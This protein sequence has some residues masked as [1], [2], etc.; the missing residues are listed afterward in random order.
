M[1]TYANWK[2][3]LNEYLQ[4]GDLVDE[5]I[6]EHFIN[7]LPPITFNGNMIQ[8]GEPYSHIPGAGGTYYTITKTI[9]GWMYTGI[10][11]RGFKTD[12]TNYRVD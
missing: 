1:K 9:E 4:V 5:D 3:S 12:M 6:V 10:C 8:M 7:V 2:G 11:L